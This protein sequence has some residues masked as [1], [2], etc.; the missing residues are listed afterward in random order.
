MHGVNGPSSLRIHGLS[1]S[2]AKIEEDSPMS[3]FRCV[4]RA[5]AGFAA[6]PFLALRLH[7][8]RL[9]PHVSLSSVVDDGRIRITACQQQ[10]HCL[11]P[12]LHHTLQHMLHQRI[13][14]H[15]RRLLRAPHLEDTCKKLANK[16]CGSASSVCSCR[17]YLLVQ[18]AD[19]MC[20]VA[21]PPALGNC[22][23][24]SS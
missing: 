16:L 11:L 3:A 7:V 15:T 14:R 9:Q 12:Y 13:S 24:R 2:S 18:S 1:L 19:R 21:L 4:S 20:N 5:D 8:C 23:R 6:R 22:P 10:P 17:S